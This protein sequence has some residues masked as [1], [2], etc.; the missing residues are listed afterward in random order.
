MVRVK[1]IA[2][3]SPEIA[4]L[5]RQV[6]ASELLQALADAYEEDLR[7][8]PPDTTYRLKREV[9]IEGLR[10]LSQHERFWS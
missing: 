10:A 3:L 6:P 4:Q 9:T 5:I 8:N 7:R 2:M 1:T